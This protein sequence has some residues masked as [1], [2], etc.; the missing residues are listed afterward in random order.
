MVMYYIIFM[1]FFKSSEGKKGMY[2]IAKTWTMLKDN[3]GDKYLLHCNKTSQKGLIPR[4]YKELL[5][6]SKKK[7]NNPV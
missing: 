4:I 1:D 3:L 7:L 5:K 2:K 6:T